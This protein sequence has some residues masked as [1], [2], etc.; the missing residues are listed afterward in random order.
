M[1]HFGDL[2]IF[3]MKL[4]ENSDFFS[5]I[6]NKNFVEEELRAAFQNLKYK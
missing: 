4:I 3:L 1:G 2:V 6:K 5:G